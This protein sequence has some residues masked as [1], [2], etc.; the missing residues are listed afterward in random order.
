V[1]PLAGAALFA[2]LGASLC[3]ADQRGTQR[4]AR[5]RSSQGGGRR[6]AD[7]PAFLVED[8]ERPFHGGRLQAAETSPIGVVEEA[9][10]EQRRCH[11]RDDLA[12]QRAASAGG[13]GPQTRLIPSWRRTRCA[14]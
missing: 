1:L 14:R 12:D 5:P 9:D 7:D 4:P 6:V 11:D 3:S 8:P 2:G 13:C 10:H